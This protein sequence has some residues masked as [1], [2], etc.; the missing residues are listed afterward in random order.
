MALM[1]Q[2]QAGDDAIAT[3]PSAG[4]DDR[5]GTTRRGLTTARR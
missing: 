2:V 4:G 1:R 5:G 3:G